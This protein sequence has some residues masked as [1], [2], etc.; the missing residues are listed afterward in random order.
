MTIFPN[1]REWIT[2]LKAEFWNQYTRHHNCCVIYLIDKFYFVKIQITCWHEVTL[3][4]KIP[5]GFEEFPSNLTLNCFGASSAALKHFFLIIINKF[6]HQFN[7]H[8]YYILLYFF[9]FL[10]NYLLGILYVLGPR[11]NLVPSGRICFC[12]NYSFRISV[13]CHKFPLILY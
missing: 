10:V 8:S 12:L 2:R 5:S 3:D 9:K 6:L 11:V 13:L 7:E 4:E 1:F